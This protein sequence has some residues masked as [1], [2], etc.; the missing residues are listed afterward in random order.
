MTTNVVLDRPAGAPADGDGPD[1]FLALV[2]AEWTKFRTVRSS[3]WGLAIGAVLAIA[4]ATAAQ[5]SP[6]PPATCSSAA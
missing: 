3:F 2:H 6:R 1:G 4:A 5:Q